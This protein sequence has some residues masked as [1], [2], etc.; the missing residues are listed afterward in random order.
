MP[1]GGGVHPI[2][3]AGAKIDRS[4][5][6]KRFETGSSPAAQSLKNV[7]LVAPHWAFFTVFS[8]SPMRWAIPRID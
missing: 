3:A 8:S 1:R 2:Q 4:S 7:T 5:A 6:P